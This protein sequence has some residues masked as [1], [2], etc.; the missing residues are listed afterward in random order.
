MSVVSTRDLEKFSRRFGKM[1]NSG[2]PLLNVL[3]LIQREENGSGIGKIT[4]QIIGKLKDGYTF[5]SCLAMFPGVFTEVYVAMV[6]ASEGQGKLD[7][8]MVEIA[9]SCA[10][11]TI[12]AGSG[13]SEIDESA[14]SSNDQNL[15]VIKMVN[16][17]ITDAVNENLVKITFK[18][19]RD[20]VKVF[21]VR[22]SRL[23]LRETLDK[24][25]YDRI[26]ARVK[27]MSAL[28]LG[29]CY[30]PQDGR[31]LVKVES[32][33]ADIRVQVVPTVFG[34]QIVLFFSPPDE[35]TPPLELIFPDETQRAVLTSLLLNLQSGIV[36]F[37][38][39]SGSGKT[40]TRDSA[41]ALLNDGSRLIFEIGR[42]YRS[43]AGISCMQVRPHLGMTMVNSIRTAVRAEPHVLVVED[44]SDE[45]SALECFKAASDGVLVLTQMSTRNSSEVFKQLFNLKVPPFQLYGGIGAVVFQVLV[46]K[47]CP[48]CRKEVEFSAEDLFRLS[49]VDMKPGKYGESKGCE[50]CKNSGYRGMQAFYEITVPDKGLKEAIIKGD[51]NQ[52]SMAIEALHG[53]S[54]EAKIRAF[55]ES[56]A[57]SPTEAARIR[58]ILCVHGN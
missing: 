57:T 44:L 1:I 34:E 46:R 3:E 31:I 41:A 26:I 10:D 27:L 43:Q 13:S 35:A 25:S 33:T 30:L 52:I 54:L 15:K 58:A 55:V 38:G 47:L 39:P 51:G 11:G 7:Q 56:G 16:Q 48:D 2:I 36:I 17:L 53:N 23:E 29:E 21:V 50:K 40:T 22:Q 32:Y 14:V 20:H 49:L 24:S 28:D 42:I 12:E 4:E 45:E 19:E 18:P 6:K 8:G 37:S 5:S 9:D